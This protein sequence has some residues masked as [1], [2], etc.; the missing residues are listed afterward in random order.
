MENHLLL[1]ESKVSNVRNRG[2]L[3]IRENVCAAETSGG[4]SKGGFM[5][6]DGRLLGH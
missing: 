4:K 1:V 2:K 6:L 5:S 3:L